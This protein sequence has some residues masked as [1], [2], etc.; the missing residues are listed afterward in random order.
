MAAADPKA[1]LEA[2][3]AD[4]P[5]LT[6]IAQGLMTELDEDKSGKLEF[7]EVEKLIQSFCKDNGCPPDKYPSKAEIQKAF[8]ALD[9]DKS[10]SVETKELIPLVKDIITDLVASM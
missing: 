3:L 2:L 8:D 7:G 10:G 6:E 1:Q 4:T 9:T 5:K